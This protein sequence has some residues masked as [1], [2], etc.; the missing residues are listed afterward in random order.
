[1]RATGKLNASDGENVDLNVRRGFLGK[2]DQVTKS[3][4]ETFFYKVQQQEGKNMTWRCK[5]K[6]IKIRPT[7][8]KYTGRKIRPT[9]KKIRPNW[10]KIRPSGRKIRPNVWKIRPPE[11]NVMPPREIAYH[12]VEVPVHKRHFC[13][14][15]RLY[16]LERR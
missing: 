1:M 10:R 15:K 9:K 7:E 16:L 11:E 4:K 12:W 13:W 6:A 5:D 14:K 2:T 8:R 3:C